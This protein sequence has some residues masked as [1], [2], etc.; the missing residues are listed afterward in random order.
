M[1]CAS[2]ASSLAREWRAWPRRE[3]RAAAV[4]SRRVSERDPRGRGWVVNQLRS[5]R[6]IS[7]A[8][9]ANKGGGTQVLNMRVGESN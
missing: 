5:C 9:T 6:T 8:R 7:L 1:L 3:G 2:H 4:H